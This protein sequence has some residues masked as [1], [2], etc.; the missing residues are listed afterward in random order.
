[1]KFVKNLL[2]F[3]LLTAIIVFFARQQNAEDFS[4]KSVPARFV[5]P[6]P[7]YVC[8]PS[9]ET[10]A[11]LDNPYCGFYHIYGFILKDESTYQSPDEVPVYDNAPERLVQLQILLSH[12]RDRPIT[13]TALEQLDIILAAYAGSGC[14]ILLRFLYDWD[15]KGMKVEPEDIQIL[16]THMEQTAGIYN[17][18]KDSILT[19]QGLSTGSY[20][21]M[22]DTSYG[23]SDSL[24]KLAEKQ[25]AVTDP[26]IYLSV[27]TPQQWRSIT[28]ADSWDELCENGASPFLGRL[29]L[30]NDGMLG[31]DTDVGT[32]KEKNREE[33]IAFQDR[34]CQTV[35]NGGEVIIDNPYNDLENAVADLSRMHVSYLNSAYHPAVIQKWKE[36]VHHSQD[37]YDGMSGFDY[38]S[39][40]LGYR[41]VLRTSEL[42][43]TEDSGFL[44]SFGIENVG[45]APSYRPF[46]F[47]LTLLSEE[48]HTPYET[49]LSVQSGE[50]AS[51]GTTVFQQPLDIGSYPAGNYRL[52]LNTRDESTG[53]VIRYANDLPL[54]EY[55]YE[56]GTLCVPT[57]ISHQWFQ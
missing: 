41:Y 52:Y 28:G 35:P 3:L 47:T 16:L 43:E 6:K 14:Q 21:E 15:G 9:Q 29:G 51:G 54:T 10:N 2:Y 18:Y 1:M 40:R 34:L 13:E 17:R 44:L 48:D 22:S 4:Y 50:I 23:T 12:F 53:E 39:L 55:G 5:R 26:L 25:A 7:V 24:R 33:E 36:S 8:T 37:C 32:Y 45:F 19:L 27:R 57:R 56:L 42:S 30:F 46:D 38:I 31:S 11:A 20:G 49:A